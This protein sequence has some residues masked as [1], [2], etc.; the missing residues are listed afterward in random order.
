[1]TVLRVLNIKYKFFLLVLT[2]FERFFFMD[3]DPDTDI[4]DPIRIF[5]RSGS[6]LRKKSSIRI[7]KKTGSETLF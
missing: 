4:P 5:G 1:M 6:G 7:R 2:V 3:P